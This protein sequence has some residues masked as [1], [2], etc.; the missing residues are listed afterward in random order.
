MTH[1]QNWLRKKKG[2]TLVDSAEHADVTVEVTRRV[3][4]DNGTEYSFMGAT[5]KQKPPHRRCRPARRGQRLDHRRDELR[6][7]DS[8]ATIPCQGENRRTFGM[9]VG[10]GRHVRQP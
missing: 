1:I 7:E 8:G 2:L 5:Y 4:K 6:L 10:T 3:Q 9:R